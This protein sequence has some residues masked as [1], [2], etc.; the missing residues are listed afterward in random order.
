MDV[1]GQ[2]RPDVVHRG[3]ASGRGDLERGGGAQAAEPAEVG[4]LQHPFLVHVGAEEARAVG[5]ERS[6]DVLGRK[7]CRFLPALD[8]DAAAPGIEGDKHALAADGVAERAEERLVRARAAERSRADD[9]LARALLHECARPLDRAHAAPD[10]G[11]GPRR[12]HAYQAVV[13]APTHG[14]VEIDHLDLGKRGELLQHGLGRIPLE[15]L[16][17]ALDQLH[18]LAVHQVDAGNDHRHGSPWVLT[19]IPRLASSSL[20]WFTVVVP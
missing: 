1:H 2:E 18:H 4:P 15:R 19:G 7:A 9:D 3:D 10:A 5:L 20:S 11:R 12:Q 16:L 17:A 6:E 13:R 14:R 8:H